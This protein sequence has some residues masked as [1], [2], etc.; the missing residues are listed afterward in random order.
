MMAV[1]PP[2]RERVPAGRSR[3]KRIAEPVIFY[4]GARV[5]GLVATCWPRAQATN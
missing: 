4:C 5:F 2:R 3:P 1:K